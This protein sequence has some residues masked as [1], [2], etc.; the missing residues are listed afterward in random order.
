MN[1]RSA[2]AANHV[3]RDPRGILGVTRRA[4]IPEIQ[5]LESN[6]GTPGS[7]LAPPVENDKLVKSTLTFQECVKFVHS[8]EFWYLFPITLQHSASDG[9]SL[10]A[11]F[12]IFDVEKHNPG[13][14]QGDIFHENLNQLEIPCP[15]DL[16]A[17]PGRKSSQ[18]VEIDSRGKPKSSKIKKIRKSRKIAG[19]LLY[20]RFF[21]FKSSFSLC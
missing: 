20:D 6:T 5:S 10:V 1:F 18:G 15:V 21:D 3:N 11:R 7:W 13:S 16:E 19:N 17:A 4:Y 12:E 8:N 2:D 14:N 9:L